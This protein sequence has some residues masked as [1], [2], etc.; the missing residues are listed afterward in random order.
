MIKALLGEAQFDAE[1]AEAFRTRWITPPQP[2]ASAIY[3]PKLVSEG[4][5]I[6]KNIA[7]RYQLYVI[8][9]SQADD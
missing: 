5:F 9:G 7:V 6:T 2:I 3:H 1:L 8:G 4:N